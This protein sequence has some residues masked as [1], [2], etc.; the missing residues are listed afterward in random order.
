MKQR[1]IDTEQ[2]ITGKVKWFSREKGY[3][4]IQPDD[5]QDVFV[6]QSDIRGTGFQ[7]L[8]EGERVQFV[9]KRSPKGPQAA[10]VVRLDSAQVKS[11]P[12]WLSPN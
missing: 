12:A 9:I 11:L 4:F 7:E 10:N 2:R 3:G 6:H 8:T 1:T 5:G